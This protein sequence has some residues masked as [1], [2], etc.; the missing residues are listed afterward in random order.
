[1]P[2]RTD[3]TFLSAG[4][5][6]A[7][8]LFTP[9]DA[10][11]R[12][13]GIVVMGHGLGLTRRAGLERYARRFSEAGLAVLVFDYR[14]FGDSGGSPRETVHVRRQLADWRAAVATARSLPGVDPARV[15]VWGT[16]FAGGH[17]LRIAAED[18]A[19]A[20]VVAQCP[21][22]DGLA[23]A[24][25]LWP[26]ALL[27][28]L[29]PLLDDLLRAATGRPPRMVAA[30]ADPGTPALMTGGD[31]RAGYEA[32]TEDGT[33]PANRLAARSGLSILAYRPGTAARRI[34]VPLLV[35]LCRE[36]ALAPA[37]TSRRHVGRAADPHIVEAPV[38][39]FEI[40]QGEHFDRTV[41]EQTA[42]LRRTLTAP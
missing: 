18:P 28:L 13:H 26:G 41:T 35:H 42:F 30:A 37:G 4:V 2:A 14:G 21:F 15:A 8:W 24:A 31:A 12:P 5:P 6:C 11:E 34:R 16:S 9:E 27:R 25:R 29:P 38:G 23:S 17:V 40:Y 33:P 36:D 10:G 3:L 1:M 7:A 19:I 39:H 32:L 22:T 20:A